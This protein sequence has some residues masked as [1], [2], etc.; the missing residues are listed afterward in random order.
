MKSH[1]LEPG[2]LFTTK[3][4]EEGVQTLDMAITD[5]SA[6]I[7]NYWLLKFVQE[8]SN[9]LAVSAILPVCCYS[10]LC[11]LKRHLS[12]LNGSASLNMSDEGKLYF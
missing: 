8:A 4:F 7:L 2:G 10:I 9:S 1:T 3:D 12:D 6:C 11:R 5:M